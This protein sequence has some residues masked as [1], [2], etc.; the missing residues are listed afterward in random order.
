[1]SKLCLFLLF[2]HDC[3]LLCAFAC[4]YVFFQV[5]ALYFTSAQISLFE[6]FSLR[7]DSDSADIILWDDLVKGTHRSCYT[8]AHLAH[9]PFWVR[10]G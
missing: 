2:L 5:S 7:M 1:M 3:V 9:E 10:K 6:R 8:M 4:V